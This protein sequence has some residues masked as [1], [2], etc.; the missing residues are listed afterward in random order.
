[1]WSHEVFFLY[2]LLT[3]LISS[4]LFGDLFSLTLPTSIQGGALS[5]VLLF[6]ICQRFFCKHIVFLLVYVYALRI[7]ITNNKRQIIIILF[8][9]SLPLSS[10]FSLPYITWLLM[11]NILYDS[12]NAWYY[13]CF[14]L[15]LLSLCR[16]SGRSSPWHIIRLLIIFVYLFLRALIHIAQPILCCYISLIWCFSNR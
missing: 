12:T 13:R 16:A 5:V 10:S 8:V 6:T 9:I 7:I 15:P 11:N 4:G 2:F 14:S 3:I 1:M